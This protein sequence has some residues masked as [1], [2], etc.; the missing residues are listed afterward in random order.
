MACRSCGRKYNLE[1]L[2]ALLS[3]EDEE[4]LGNYRADRF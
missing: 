3:D 1:E 4:Q 2:S